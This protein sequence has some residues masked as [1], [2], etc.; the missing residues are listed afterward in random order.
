MSEHERRREEQGITGPEIA[1][2]TMGLI[3]AAAAVSFF[4][5]NFGLF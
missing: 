3:I 4:I 5:L 2:L 1:V